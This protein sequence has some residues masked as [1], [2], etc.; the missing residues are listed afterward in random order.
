MK[1]KPIGSKVL[2]RISKEGVP[3]VVIRYNESSGFYNKERYPYIVK[4][5]DGSVYEES[6]GA[7]IFTDE[8]VPVENK[9]EPVE[10]LGMAA[11]SP[12]VLDKYKDSAYREMFDLFFKALSQPISA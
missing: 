1:L 6:E 10:P 5:D 4:R 12:Q 9:N 11:I 8:I 2:I 7:L 3:G